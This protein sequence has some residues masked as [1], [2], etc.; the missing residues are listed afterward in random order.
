VTHPSKQNRVVDII[1]S[2][3]IPEDDVLPMLLSPI[4]RVADEPDVY[5][6]PDDEQSAP[7]SREDRSWL[8]EELHT[9]T[10]H[11]I[12]PPLRW[13]EG[14][15]LLQVD[16]GAPP[17]LLPSERLP[18]RL[19][20][21]GHKAFKNTAHAWER[22]QREEAASWAWRALRA[23]PDQPVALLAV[24]AIER[25]GLPETGLAELMQD[26]Q[27]FDADQITNS[28]EP[29]QAI[30]EF[31]PLI[32]LIQTDAAYRAFAE[33]P[34]GTDVLAPVV[35]MPAYLGRYAEAPRFIAD[36]RRA[37]QQYQRAS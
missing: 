17:E 11:S 16:A 19:A 37:W 10:M 12:D 4:L 33:E 20:E 24:I 8:D 31:A 25:D 29:Y 35:S 27:R 3:E 32:E 22:E 26:L 15:V 9:G 13:Q 2:T 23:Q 21:I 14:H 7:W 1:G 30:H 28:I 34:S 18:A 5:Y 6:V 36:S